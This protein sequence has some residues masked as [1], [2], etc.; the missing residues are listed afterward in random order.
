MKLSCREEALFSRITLT[1]TVCIE[2][3]I[4]NYRRNELK[5]VTE[6]VSTLIYTF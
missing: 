3:I 4:V 2:C 5:Y 6:D 1:E